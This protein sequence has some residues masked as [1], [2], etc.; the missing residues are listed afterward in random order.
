VYELGIGRDVIE[1]GRDDLRAIALSAAHECGAVADGRLD[2]RGDELRGLPVERVSI[3]VR[4][5]IS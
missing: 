2:A 3:I 1:H 4:A 5:G